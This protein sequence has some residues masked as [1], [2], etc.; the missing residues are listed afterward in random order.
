M[1]TA[2]FKVFGHRLE[3]T[4]SLEHALINIWV[5]AKVPSTLV[6]GFRCSMA[7]QGRLG[8]WGRRA[9]AL[10]QAGLAAA[11]LSAEVH[12]CPHCLPAHT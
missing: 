12:C 7:S 8:P 5:S 4:I 9:A 11:S 3:F 1:V 6:L 10:E 2:D